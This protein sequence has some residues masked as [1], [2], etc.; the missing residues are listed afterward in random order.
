MQM[1]QKP[2]FLKEKQD[3]GQYFIGYLRILSVISADFFSQNR[4]TFYYFGSII[5]AKQVEFCRKRTRAD[6]KIGK[7]PRTKGAT[8]F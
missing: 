5:Q 1:S 7:R 2:H 8:D 3:L 6:E 4:L